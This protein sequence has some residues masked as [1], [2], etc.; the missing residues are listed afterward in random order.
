VHELPL[1]VTPGAVRIELSCDC[2]RG[3]VWARSAADVD[4]AR[5]VVKAAVA[6]HAELAE[7]TE[8]R[9]A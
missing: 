1:V 3:Y 4:T 8:A 7:E 6:R 5:E 9:K 2:L